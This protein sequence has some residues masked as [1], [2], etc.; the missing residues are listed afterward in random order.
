MRSNI[1]SLNLQ[2]LLGPALT[3]KGKRVNEYH[4]WLIIDM[5]VTEHLG[6]LLLFYTLN[7]GQLLLSKF[8]YFCD[9]NVV[10]VYHVE[11]DGGIVHTCNR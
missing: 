10:S 1:V 11:S 7:R 2:Y 8:V 5:E 6:E 4:T 9:V 3:P